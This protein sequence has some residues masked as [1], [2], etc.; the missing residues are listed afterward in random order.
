MKKVKK[1][2]LSIGVFFILH[3]GY[4]LQ[5][6]EVVLQTPEWNFKAN[7]A[8]NDIFEEYYGQFFAQFGSNMAKN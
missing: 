4:L 7:V 6:K 2:A 8:R 5:Q 3:G 1:K